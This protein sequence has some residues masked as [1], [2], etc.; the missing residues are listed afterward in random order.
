VNTTTRALST[1]D[2]S[3]KTYKDVLTS[4]TTWTRAVFNVSLNN[5]GHVTGAVRSEET[6][7]LFVTTDIIELTQ[8]PVKWSS[9]SGR[10]QLYSL[11]SFAETT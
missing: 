1:C 11:I 9:V 5:S 2:Y 8:V 4:S 7:R 3:T 6:T 10:A